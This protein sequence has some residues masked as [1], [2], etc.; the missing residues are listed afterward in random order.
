MA[1]P[2][3]EGDAVTLLCLFEVGCEVAKLLQV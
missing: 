3:L 2:L 1:A